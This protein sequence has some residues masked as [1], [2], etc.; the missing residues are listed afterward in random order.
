MKN[1][2]FLPLFLVLVQHDQIKSEILKQNAL[3]FLINSCQSFSDRSKRLLLESLGSMTF[4]QEAVRV[5][6][7]KTDFI[8]S[9]EHMQTTT[10][11]GIKKAAEKI[12][13][14]LV[15]G[16]DQRRTT[17]RVSVF[18]LSPSEPERVKRTKEE[19]KT[20]TTRSADQD[21]K[22]KYQYDAMISYCHA[23]KE[24]V[25]RIHQYLTEQGFKVWF[26]QENIYGPGET[27]TMIS[28]PLEEAVRYLIVF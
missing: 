25:R 12:M 27:V 21:D 28:E 10:D 8:Q 23:D 24:L 20:S 3:S 26:D 7:P 16:I 5:L 2:Q 4:D 17:T 6:R 14:N 18:S 15:K 1:A 13:W 22:V 9:L 11:E 19:K